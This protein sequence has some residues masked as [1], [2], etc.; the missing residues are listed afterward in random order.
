MTDGNKMTLGVPRDSGSAAEALL[1]EEFER[2][3][4]A[5]KSWQAGQ[6]QMAEGHR[7]F[8]RLWAGIIKNAARLHGKQATRDA[9]TNMGRPEDITKMY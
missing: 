8:D 5:L 2:C 9:L 3:S 4:A 6:A 1:R 7:E